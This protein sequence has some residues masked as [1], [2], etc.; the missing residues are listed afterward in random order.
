MINDCIIICSFF[1][2]K[3][4]FFNFREKLTDRIDV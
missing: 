4:E 2:E 1:N 3:I